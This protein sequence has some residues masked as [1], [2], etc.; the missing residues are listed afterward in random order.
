MDIDETR[1]VPEITFP[2][3]PDSTNEE[4]KSYLTELEI[5]LKTGLRASMLFSTVFDEGK[6]GN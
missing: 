4:M 1:I 5:I 6:L 2:V 3:I